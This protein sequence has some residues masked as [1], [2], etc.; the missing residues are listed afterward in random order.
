MTPAALRHRLRPPAVLLVLLLAQGCSDS[1]TE[2][3]VDPGDAPTILSVSPELLTPGSEATLTGANFA[4]NPQNNTVTVWGT[5]VSVLGGDQESLTIR[6]PDFVCGPSGEAP[7]VVAAGS[8]SG[9]AFRHPF[10]PV[11]TR[12]L[13]VGQLVRIPAPEARCLILDPRGSRADYLVGIQSTTGTA[14][15]VAGVEVRGM[16]GGSTAAASLSVAGRTF[17]QEVAGRTLSTP[18]AHQ[19][20]HGGELAAIEELMAEHRRGESEIRRREARLLA[21]GEL[22]Q[23]R[24]GP[25][26]AGAHA[27]GSSPA[28]VPANVQPGDTVDLNVPDLTTDNFCQNGRAIRAVVRR[29]GDNS[30]W[31]EDVENPQGGFT[32][33]DYDLLSDEFDDHIYEELVSWFGEPTDLDNNGRVVIVISEQVNRVTEQ[34][35]GFVVSVDF[36][37]DQCPGGNGGEYYYARAP[38]PQGVVPGPDGETGNTL[39]RQRARSVASLLLAHETTH[40]IQFGRRF[41]IP[42][43]G[44]QQIWILEGQATLAEEV[45]GH[46]YSGLQPRTNLG[47]SVVFGE[48][49][50]TEVSWYLNG[51]FGLVSY[52]GLGFD[53]DS[54]FRVED[55]PHR[56]TWLSV[57]D[58]EPCDTGLVA[59]GTTWSFLRWMSDHFGDRFGGGE[60]E[61]QRRII[62]SSRSGFVTFEDLLGESRAELLAPWA[63]SLFADGRVQGTPD[64]LLT[65]PSWN[66]PGI[67]SGII[68]QAHL[69]PTQRTF[70]DF[71]SEV[72]VAAASSYYQLMQ[73]TAAGH[74][75]FAV[76][77]RTAAGD[78][79][80]DHMQLWVVR[81]R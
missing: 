2:N 73:G 68:Q 13:S 47:A 33:D 11:G 18:S 66:L 71:E 31:V 72:E 23:S 42:G 74:P 54:P 45:V 44:T 69:R 39:S 28:K 80:P 14:G 76:S 34:A 12:E 3:D 41:Q 60:R 32:S 17:S 78:P 70:N 15:T 16:R 1:P 75:A 61:F 55:A 46:S 38:D 53:N 59:Y 43:A 57:E 67:E 22:L 64:P 51:I 58:H 63:A 79:L 10:E 56:C 52:F 62:D 49:D 6:L 9:A 20:T 36:F 30:I 37:P 40:I 5:R 77:A 50:P 81:L 25:A 4:A 65:F 24:A 19:T 35:L 48:Y 21:S 8:Q 7:V 26:L 27:Q 29:V